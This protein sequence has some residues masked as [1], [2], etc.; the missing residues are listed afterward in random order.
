VCGLGGGGGGGLEL[1]VILVDGAAEALE[2]VRC[3]SERR[4]ERYSLPPTATTA[5][6]EA[7]ASRPAHAARCGVCAVWR[8]AVWRMAGRYFVV[9]VVRGR[10]RGGVCGVCLVLWCALCNARGIMACV[11]LW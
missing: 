8:C 2:H 3:S 7:S 11:W 10:V 5:P 9:R 1:C 6:P 4:S